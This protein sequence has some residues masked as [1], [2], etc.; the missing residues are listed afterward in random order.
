MSCFPCS[1]GLL[2]RLAIEDEVLTLRFLQSTKII[3]EREEHMCAWMNPVWCS[4]ECP[5]YVVVSV[6]SSTIGEHA[7]SDKRKMAISGGLRAQMGLPLV[8]SYQ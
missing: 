2:H 1:A 7:T 5:L 4:P 3:V 6:H 8:T